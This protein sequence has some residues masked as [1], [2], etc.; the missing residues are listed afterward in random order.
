M[1]RT[2]SREVTQPGYTQMTTAEN[3]NVEEEEYGVRPSYATLMR[4]TKRV[5][6]LE[7]DTYDA[8]FFASCILE[9]SSMENHFWERFQFVFALFLQLANVFLQ[10][11]LV[12]LL[13]ATVVEDAENP[14]EHGLTA[15]TAEMQRAIAADQP[16]D[17]HSNVMALCRKDHTL[18]GAHT[19]VIML[20]LSRMLREII[21][22]VNLTKIYARMKSPPPPVSDH[23]ELSCEII[24]EVVDVDEKGILV[25]ESYSIVYLTARLRVLSCVFL[26]CVRV[27]MAS[28]LTFTGAKYLILEGNMSNVI[29]KAVSMQFIVTLDALL[30]KAFMPQT[31]AKRMKAAKIVYDGQRPELWLQWT[32]SMCYV[33]IAWAMMSVL[34]NVIFGKLDTFRSSCREYYAAF[35]KERDMAM[36]LIAAFRQEAG[37]TGE[38]FTW[39]HRNLAR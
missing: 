19:M 26:G 37:E 10:F 14:Y 23:P 7:L 30:F 25:E 27:A 17:R 36:D 15:E 20:W 4:Q 21:E 38:W 33:M 28:F 3:R 35:P 16:I 29:L 18:A 9:D 6:D 32:K 39:F 11:M 31:F 2:N 13:F 8:L 34:A 12:F 24:D 5:K 1:P 22:A